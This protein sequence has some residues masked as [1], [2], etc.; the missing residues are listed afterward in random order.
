MSTTVSHMID[1]PLEFEFDEKTGLLSV[2][3]LA[4]YKSRV[5][6]IQMTQQLLLTPATGKALLEALPQ[7]RK[8]LERQGEGPTKPSALQ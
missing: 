2:K 6:S 3:A 4:S 5:H 8:L 7:L 1:A